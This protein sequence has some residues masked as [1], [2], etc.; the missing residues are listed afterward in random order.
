MAEKFYAVVISALAAILVRWCVSLS[1]YSGKIWL[2]RR[3]KSNLFEEK[4]GPYITGCL[5]GQISRK[6]KA[7]D[8][9]RLRSAE[10]LDGNNL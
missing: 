5:L 9:W 8:V 3:M 4:S 10:T 6:R 2:E 7:T 1:P